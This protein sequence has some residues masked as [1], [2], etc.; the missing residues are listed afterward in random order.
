MKKLMLL[1]VLLLVLTGCATKEPSIFSDFVPIPE[2]FEAQ[3]ADDLKG[4]VLEYVKLSH[5]YDELFEWV[6]EGEAWYLKVYK[7]T[8]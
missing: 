8:R 7:K 5:A 2:R 3:Q 4:I 6:Q 1:T